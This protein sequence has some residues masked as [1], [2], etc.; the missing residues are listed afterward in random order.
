MQ[1]GHDASHFACAHALTLTDRQSARAFWP[2]RLSTQVCAL[3]SLSALLRLARLLGSRGSSARASW[4]FSRLA[5]LL[6]PSG[7]ALALVWLGTQLPAQLDSALPQ[8]SAWPRLSSA[9]LRSEHV[10]CW[11]CLAQI[12]SD[13]LRS[14]SAR[15]STAICLATA[16]SASPLPYQFGF[17]VSR[18]QVWFLGGTKTEH[19]SFLRLSP[20]QKGI[21][22]HSGPVERGTRLHP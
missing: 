22:K 3:S 12:S 16:I 11:H 2:V 8:R 10:G 18:Q 1:H 20:F 7:F 19:I 4:L 21:L 6:G 5:P 14:A 13:Q 17:D 15:H 9:W